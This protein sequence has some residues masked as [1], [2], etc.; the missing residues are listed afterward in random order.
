MLTYFIVAYITIVNKV[1]E[2]MCQID[3][4]LFLG[5]CFSDSVRSVVLIDRFWLR[6]N[7]IDFGLRKKTNSNIQTWLEIDFP[8]ILTKLEFLEFLSSN[9]FRWHDD[10]QLSKFANFE[11]LSCSSGLWIFIWTSWVFTLILIK[12]CSISINSRSWK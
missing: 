8:W 9:S 12:W 2:V 4:F 1:L 11:F 3:H 10:K 7:L 6:L 5:N